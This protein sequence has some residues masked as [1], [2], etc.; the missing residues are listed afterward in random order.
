MFLLFY[1]NEVRIMIAIYGV[2]D[3]ASPRFTF[4]AFVGPL[5]PQTYSRSNDQLSEMVSTWTSNA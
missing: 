2:Q 4:D 5:I 1:Y 3:S